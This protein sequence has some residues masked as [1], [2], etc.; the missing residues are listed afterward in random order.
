MRTLIIYL[1]FLCVSFAGCSDFLKEDPNGLVVGTSAISNVQ[2]LDA[3]LTG[4]YKGLLRTWARGFLTNGSLQGTTMGADDLTT[5][6]SGNKQ[7]YRQFDQFNVTNLNNISLQIWNGCYKTIQG[8]NNV[9]D[10]YKGITGDQNKIKQ[11]AGEAYFLRGL[12]YY[13]LVREYGRI[14]LITT[15]EYSESLLS[16]QKSELAA[17][18]DYIVNDLLTA[19]EMLGNVKRDPGRPNKGSATAQL[20]DV[21]LTMAGWPIKDAT[22]Y[23]LAAAKA[24][25]V[26]DNKAA[27]GFELVPEIDTLWSG[28][29][30]A[31]G[32]SEEVMSF[33]SSDLY[34][35]SGNAFWAVSG[36]PGEAGGWDDYFAE[37][38][39]F[40][41]FPAGK[42][43][44]A[45]FL[46]QWKSASSGAMILWQNSTALHPYFKKFGTKKGNYISNMPVHII[47]YAHVL[48]TYAEA[49]AQSAGNANTSAY[50]ALNAVR[51]RA[52]LT[53]LSG[54]SNDA[55]VKAVIDERAWEF[56]GEWTR[57]FDLVRL[58]MVESANALS[59]KDANDLKPIG[60][61][62]KANYTFPIPYND[63]N[64][65]SNL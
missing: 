12:S 53:P 65:N 3:A 33:H 45:T 58:E 39:F 20:A 57:W 7:M 24:K 28:A 52:G 30:S 59:N 64:I 60:I 44:D 25:D 55:F 4:T 5:L 18:Y 14:P 54:L 48:L 19:E 26:I 38:G 2:G 62:T 1:F 22:K 46:T 50:D 35:G 41:R 16:I 61:I 56:A 43:K 51:T 21:Y 11:I 63:S 15:S 10:H 23:A 31:I 29:A 34:G 8:A 6:T 17:I 47:R 32:T 37:I 40:N 36:T 27:Y 13:W 42:R 9:I 49:Q